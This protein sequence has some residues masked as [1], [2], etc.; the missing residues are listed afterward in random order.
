MFPFGGERPSIARMVP[1]WSEGQL[2]V[3]SVGFVSGTI[4]FMMAA[5]TKP[6]RINEHHTHDA[7]YWLPKLVTDQ[8][9]AEIPVPGTAKAMMTIKPQFGRI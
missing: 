4:P 3:T 2:L 7:A 5:P 9:H 8:I 1:T 6:F